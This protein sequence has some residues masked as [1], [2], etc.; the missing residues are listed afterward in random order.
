MESGCNPQGLSHSWR[1]RRHGRADRWWAVAHRLCV[2]GGASLLGACTLLSP[3]DSE[4][5]SGSA[6]ATNTGG[7]A[8]TGADAGATDGAG[9]SDAAGGNT[10]AEDCLN[11]VDDDGD[12]KV[13]CEDDDCEQGGYQC[14]ANAPAGWGGPYAYYS[15][16]AP[17]PACPSAFPTLTAS[18]GLNLK[19]AEASCPVCSCAPPVGAKCQAR[20]VFQNDPSCYQGGNIPVDGCTDLPPSSSDR[21]KK[22]E[23]VVGSCDPVAAGNE[24]IAPFLWDVNRV[25][26]GA[27]EVGA[28]CSDE[29]VCAG[30]PPLPFGSRHCIARAGAHAC[31]TPFAQGFELYGGTQDTRSCSAC[32]CDGPKGFLCSSTVTKYTE[33]GCAGTGSAVSNCSSFSTVGSVFAT[34]IL[35]GKGSCAAVGGVAAGT[36]EKTDLTTVCCLP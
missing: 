10:G 31:P 14:V 36:V 6:A 17:A 13:D 1:A 3:P 23:V 25:I 33:K 18:G 19:Y 20:V 32:T 8:N 7:G 35:N 5:L 26:C 27:A 9:A 22:D 15:G 24:T 11:G 4:Y 34:A 16:D 12:N 30:K 21:I 29:S 2:V 28:G